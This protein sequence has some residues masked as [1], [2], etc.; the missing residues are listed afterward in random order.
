MLPSV[1]I[2]A[3]VLKG[4]LKRGNIAPYF[5]LKVLVRSPQSGQVPL[6]HKM[7]N[8]PINATLFFE[9]RDPLLIGTALYFVLSCFASPLLEFTLLV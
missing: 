4:R 9:A 8:R 3:E 6:L 7:M 2:P 5:L 1:Q